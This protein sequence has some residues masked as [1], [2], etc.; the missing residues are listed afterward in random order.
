MATVFLVDE[1]RATQLASGFVTI[2]QELRTPYRSPKPVPQVLG[3]SYHEW[4]RSLKSIAIRRQSC[5]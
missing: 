3:L 4:R 2:L 5:P 1:Q